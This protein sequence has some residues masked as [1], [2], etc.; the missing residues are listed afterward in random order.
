MICAAQFTGSYIHD[1]LP[2]TSS[3]D[4]NS[5]V[6]VSSLYVDAS[7]RAH[8]LSAKVGRQTRSSGGVLGRF[9]GGLFTVGVMPKWKLNAVA[10][11]PVDLSANN[12]VQTNHTLYGMSLDGSGLAEH[13]DTSVFAIH[14]TVDGITDRTAV[15]SE[16]RYFTTRS[17]VFT[18]VDYDVSYSLLNTVLTQANWQFESGAGLNLALDYRLSPTLHD[19]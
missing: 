4:S 2:N 6:S 8:Q 3:D 15:G 7:D 14:Q 10:G 13:W 17:S 19:L 1:F 5:G 12:T 18:L 11:A 9:D 16:L